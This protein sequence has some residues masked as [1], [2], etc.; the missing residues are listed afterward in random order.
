MGWSTWVPAR[1]R[2]KTRIPEP[3]KLSESASLNATIKHSCASMGSTWRSSISWSCTAVSLHSQN[4]A[5]S[6]R[7]AARSSAQRLWRTDFR[8]RTHRQL[9][10]AR[11]CL[12]GTGFAARGQWTDRGKRRICN[13]QPQHRTDYQPVD[14]RL[15]P[16]DYSVQAA[17]DETRGA[18]PPLLTS[19]VGPGRI[20]TT[21][22]L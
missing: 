22:S 3:R 14:V 13:A 12:M 16:Q 6:A 4:G 5:A 8:G 21:V 2:M 9:H 1:P 17:A 15:V 10:D 7:V 11:D 20:E 19:Y 18:R